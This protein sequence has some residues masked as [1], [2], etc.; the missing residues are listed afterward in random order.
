MNPNEESLD[1]LYYDQQADRHVFIP[2]VEQYQPQRCRQNR[3]A[4]AAICAQKKVQEIQPS[5]AR[6]SKNCG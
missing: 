1:Y 3:L 6:C 5:G 4:L 2:Y